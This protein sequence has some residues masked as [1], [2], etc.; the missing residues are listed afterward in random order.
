[1]RQKKQ[2]ELE[3]LAREAVVELQSALAR[4]NLS[5]S[6]KSHLCARNQVTSA[7]ARPSSS[8]FPFKNLPRPHRISIEHDRKSMEIDGN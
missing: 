2:Q 6:F 7:E 1:M 8:S 3:V 4:L 5:T